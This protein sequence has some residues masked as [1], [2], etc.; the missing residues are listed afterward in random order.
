MIN[1][2][3]SHLLPLALAAAFALVCVHFA[4]EEQA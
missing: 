3:V 1:A 2:L 4:P